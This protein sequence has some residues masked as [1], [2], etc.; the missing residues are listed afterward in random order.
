[1]NLTPASK[2]QPCQLAEDGGRALIP[3]ASRIQPFGFWTPVPGP[4]EMPEC[5]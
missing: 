3:G 2:Q 1:M 4:T 5:L